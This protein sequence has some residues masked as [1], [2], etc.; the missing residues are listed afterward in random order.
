MTPD[1][2]ARRAAGGT[3]L[4]PLAS[5]TCFALGRAV[6][7][8]AFLVLALTR[9]FG[10]PMIV[11]YIAWRVFRA[12]FTLHNVFTVV[13]LLYVT[14]GAAFAALAAERILQEKVRAGRHAEEEDG[15][16]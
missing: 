1:Q 3:A 6:V 13:H 10:I 2:A 9:R 4:A 5:R 14:A 12:T 8:L 11:G 15:S 16:R 7:R